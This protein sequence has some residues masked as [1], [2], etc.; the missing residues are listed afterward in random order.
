MGDVFYE[1]LWNAPAEPDMTAA[2]TPGALK[3]VTL[4][5]NYRPGQN[6]NYDE[7]AVNVEM[8]LK[9]RAVLA[10]TFMGAT[11]WRETIEKFRLF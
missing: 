2:L 9:T 4:W 6:S 10:Q 8:C 3:Y 11:A 7:N 1:A 5:A